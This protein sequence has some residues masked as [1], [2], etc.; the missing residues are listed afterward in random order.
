MSQWGHGSPEVPPATRH[1]A[2]WPVTP[3]PHRSLRS[4][5]PAE[6]GP[7]RLEAVLGEGGMGRVFLGRTPAG[8]A[9][10][11]KVVHREYAADPAF[12]KR[13]EQEVTTAKR[14]QGI[15]TAPVVDADI[16]A[17]EPWLA[18]AYIP[19]PSLQYA[20]TEYGPLRVE[21]ALSLVA[22]VA[23]ALQS[24]HAADVIHR[25]LK[26]SNVILTGEG[27]K[28]IDFGIARAADVTSITG[29][30]IGPGTPAY[31]APEHI[32]GKTLTPAADVFALGLVANFA[33]TGE[34]AFGGGSALVVIRR[35][36][37]HEPNL[38]LCPEP[39]RAITAACL[40]KD[41]KR[42][43]TP[44]E[45]IQQC[46][47]AA[48]PGT[49]DGDGHISPSPPTPQSVAPTASPGRGSGGQPP[50][51]TKR[52]TGL[53]GAFGPPAPRPRPTIAQDIHAPTPASPMP[54]LRG[55]AV[56]GIVTAAGLA[57]ALIVALVVSLGTP[58]NSPRTNSSSG[59]S[60]S[61]VPAFSPA[62]TI[63]DNDDVFEVAFSPNG[64]TLATAI[65]DDTVTLWVVGSRKRRARLGPFPYYM[66]SLAFS[67]NGK[68]LATGG[69][70]DEKVRLWDVASGKQRAILTGLRDNINSLAFSPDGK[71]FAAATHSTDSTAGYVR[72]WD[73]ASRKQRATLGDHH[74]VHS[75]RFSPDGKTLATGD[76][77]GARLWDVASGKKRATLS[78]DGDVAIQGVAF[79]PD[80]KTL[81]TATGDLRVGTVR[82]WDVASG[83]ERATL[84]GH[85]SSVEG[86]AFSPNGQLLASASE[87]HTVRL[88]D[89]ATG[90]QRATLTGH[91]DKVKSVAFS[92]NGQMLASGSDDATVRLWK[93]PN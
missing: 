86:V 60:P 22:R 21:A 31:M 71:T 32:D 52:Y 20:V 38:E 34:L 16:Q 3:P 19:G 18:T 14:V 92:P 82:L 36:A 56:P 43:P 61:T 33:A 76:I 65:L 41:P 88:W 46:R 5:D 66:T 59:A 26:P 10:A 4:A 57:L 47:R 51:A 91:F 15:Y 6:V 58:S 44:A 90:K 85:S 30:G 93:V 87:D 84:T 7:Y 79:S 17:D 37:E 12:R 48:T 50:T 25:D 40:A 1:E 70:H 67:P 74:S 89:V 83:Q 2:G 49:N 68:T 42:R 69:P 63:T 62:A 24:I 73:V 28:V 80:G 23:E 64:K 72:L 35:I 75:V 27:P 53:P 13:F 54:P 9:V 39:V 77:D 29:T 45:V 11:V 78:V 8:S 55:L 81:A